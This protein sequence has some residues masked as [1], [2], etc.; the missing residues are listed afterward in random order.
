MVQFIAIQLQFSQNLFSTTMQFH[1][2]Y[3]HD[4]IL[5]SL[6]VIHLLK[7]N[8]WHYEKFGHKFFSKY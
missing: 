8:M 5:T 1:Y 4:V 3:T 7:S 6:I 2:N